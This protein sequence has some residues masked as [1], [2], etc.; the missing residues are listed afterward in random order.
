MK[1]DEIKK[2]LRQLLKG[3]N[4]EELQ[5]MLQQLKQEKKRRSKSSK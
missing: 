2:I 5:K 3:L 1:E 4:E